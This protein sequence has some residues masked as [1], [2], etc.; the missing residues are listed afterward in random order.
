[1]PASSSQISFTRFFEPFKHRRWG[2]RP[3]RQMWDAF[4]DSALRGRMRAL[5]A[6]LGD[7]EI[8]NCLV[9]AGRTD[10]HG[11]PSHKR[12]RQ[13]RATADRAGGDPNAKGYDAYRD[14]ERECGIHVGLYSK[15]KR[16]AQKQHIATRK[17]E[18]DGI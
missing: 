6:Q 17:I 11:K 13:R 18:A 1:M 12:P 7:F 8:A 9:K 14:W 5:Q 15:E 3:F 16:S 2:D 10:D 4:P